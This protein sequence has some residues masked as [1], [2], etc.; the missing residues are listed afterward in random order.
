MKGKISV[1]E[2]TEPEEMRTQERE[3][4]EKFIYVTLKNTKKAFKFSKCS[5]HKEMPPKNGKGATQRS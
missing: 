4:E 2:N 5:V 3:G 1:H